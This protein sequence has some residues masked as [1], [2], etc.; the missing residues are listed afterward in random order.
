MLDSLLQMTWYNPIFMIVVIGAIWFI[1][2]IIVRRI[3]EKR[4]EDARAK[5]QAEKISRLYPKDKQI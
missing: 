1:P 5:S 3:A 4:Y 2:G